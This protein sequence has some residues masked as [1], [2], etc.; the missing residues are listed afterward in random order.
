M[1]VSADAA[2]GLLLQIPCFHHIWAGRL[3]A[4]RVNHRL[5]QVAD[6]AAGDAVR[7]NLG[8]DADGVELCRR[9][10]QNR[11]HERVLRRG[12]TGR[13]HLIIGIERFLHFRRRSIPRASVLS[14]HQ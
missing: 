13:D 4:P 7:P 2:R 12:V 14:V 9:A 3:E 11:L 10:F 5:R 6:S 1:Y 8:T